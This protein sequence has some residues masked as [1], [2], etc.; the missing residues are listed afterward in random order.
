VNWPKL[1]FGVGLRPVHYPDILEKHPP[2]DWFEAVTENFMDTYGRPL[3]VLEEIR[4]DYPVGLHGVSL[5][6][7]SADPLN[8]DYLR[9]LKSLVDRIDPALVTDHLCW[10]GVD[11][12]NLHDL[13][14]LPFTDEA[15]DHVA[16]RVRLVQEFLGRRILLENASAYVSFKHSTMS[17]WDFMSAIAVR[18]DCGI[19]LDVNNLYVNA[20]NFGFD[21][22]TY[23][24]ALPSERVGQFH[25]AGHTNKGSYF[26]DTHDGHV[27]E[28]VWD[29]YRRAVE[30]FGEASTLI[31]WDAKIPP[32]PELLAEAERARNI[33]KEV[34]GTCEV[35]LAYA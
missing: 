25:L 20:Y 33:Q 23:L 21:A 2:V 4:K 8:R 9:K 18:A 11:G 12:A 13:L 14:P 28:S 10:T 7:G 1:G 27:I 34:Y 30:R 32:F 3:H 29:L 26:F 31:E 6:I 5:S 15:V 16:G 17:E 22:E 24:K 35:S 19:L